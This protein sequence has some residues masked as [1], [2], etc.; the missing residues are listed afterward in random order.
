ML[1]SESV[2]GAEELDAFAALVA[3]REQ[4]EP[5]A[6][7]LARK[8]FRRITLKVDSR[9]LIP[10]PETEL[11]IEAALGL[12]ARARVLDV[13]TGSGAVALALKDERPDLELTGSEIDRDA[14]SL[15][16]ENAAGLGLDV[17]FVQADLLDGVQGRFDAV[18]ANLPYVE[19]GAEL[20][21]EIARFEPP[22]ALFAGEGGLDTIRRLV[23]Q[24]AGIPGS[25]F[26]VGAGQASEVAGSSARPARSIEVRR[27]WP[28]TNGWWSRSGDGRG[29][30][31][32]FERCMAVGGVAVFPPTRS[33]GSHAIRPTGSRCSGSTRSSAGRSQS[34]PR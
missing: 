8:E 15:A 32:A 14:L 27:I 28:G 33:T 4:R 31:R 26:E 13:G 17:R 25:R 20:A 18:L 16:R 7:I 10:R 12:P 2:V 11:L 34:P 22:G 3:R 5:V 21:P 29:R 24:L 23:E 19:D 6:Y 1:D 9:A 30:G